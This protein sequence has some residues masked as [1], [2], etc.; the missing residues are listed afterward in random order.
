MTGKQN[1]E[2]VGQ[3][4]QAGFSPKVI[5][6]ILSKLTQKGYITNELQVSL[7]YTKLDNQFRRYF[8]GFKTTDFEKMETILNQG[9]K[10]TL[11]ITIEQTLPALTLE[12]VLIPII[13][14]SMSQ[15]NWRVLNLNLN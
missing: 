11:R 3:F 2:L 6:K 1:E 14:L 5:K 4:E 9:R 13:W 15:K 12:S 8:P 10:E 7:K